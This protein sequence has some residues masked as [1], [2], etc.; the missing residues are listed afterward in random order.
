MKRYSVILF[1]LL[2]ASNYSQVQHLTSNKAAVISYVSARKLKIAQEIKEI[3]TLLEKEND[4]RKRGC[5]PKPV[6][7]NR[8]RTQK[9]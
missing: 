2:G 4:K 9:Q 8:E 1:L 5:Y 7:I 6:L 3:N